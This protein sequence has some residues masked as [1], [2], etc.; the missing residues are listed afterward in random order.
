M[1]NSLCGFTS[2]SSSFFGSCRQLMSEKRVGS[3]FK[4]GVSSGRKLQ[5]SR[6]PRYV[7]PEYTREVPGK[8]LFETQDIRSEEGSKE[9]RGTWE[10]LRKLLIRID[11]QRYPAYKDL[12][13]GWRHPSFFLAVENIQSDPFAPPSRFR[14]LIPRNIAGFPEQTYNSKP[15][16]VALRDFITRKFWAS[17]HGLHLDK[18]APNRGWGGSKGANLNIDKPKQHILE[19]SSC[20]FT[21]KF[22]ELRFTVALP[23]RGRTIEGNRAKEI[24][25]DGLPQVV[26]SSCLMEN[27]DYDELMDHIKVAEDQE[28]LR[29]NLKSMKLIAFVA[30]GAV[31]PRKSGASDEPL[32]GSGVVHFES[33]ESMRV[34]FRL[35]NHGVITGMGIPE[36]VTLIVGGGFHGKSTLLQALEVGIYNHIRGDGREF[37]CVDPNT[38]KIRAED[39]RAVTCVDIS[40]F[41]KNLPFGK[42]TQSFSTEDASGS[43]SQ[44]ANIMEAVE[45]GATTLLVDEDTC[46]TNFMIRDRRMQV[47][48]SKDKEPIT[49]FISRVRDMYEKFGI[50]TI[51]VIGGS[52][53][54]FDVCDTVILMDSYRPYD[55]TKRAKEIVTELPSMAI[56][57]ERKDSDTFMLPCMRAP[58]PASLEGARRG[59]RG[60]IRATDLYTIEFGSGEIELDA[61]EQLVDPSQTRAVADTLD[62]LLDA[63]LIDGK[64]VIRELLDSIE[65]LIDQKG[66]DCIAPGRAIFGNYARPRRLELA[67]AL[68]RLRGLQVTQKRDFSRSSS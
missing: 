18:A 35:P 6:R 36:G 17:C 22:V 21:D 48:V 41:I 64:R 52:G 55:V 16:E 51:L 9:L 2:R 67:A 40:S 24:L 33:P 44:A 58:I 20:V 38:T 37:V 30:D 34:S 50:S 54:Y 61:V 56:E 65:V 23:A 25:I 26:T 5:D 4:R 45:A 60:R 43:T 31:L 11:G 68:N 13:G 32:I 39:G 66:L 59:G 14:V 8:E 3:V 57:A 42:D 19:R 49:P 12:Y 15:R 46:A 27:L 63:G 29:S 7:L 62:M 47:L 1:W 10:D 28:F 53:D